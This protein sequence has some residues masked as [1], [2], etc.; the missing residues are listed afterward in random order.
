MP[1]FHVRVPVTNVEGT[2]TFAVEADSK[3]EAIAKAEHGDGDD[4]VEEN[5]EVMGL[6]WDA[7]DVEKVEE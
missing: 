1:K 2:Q 4:F 7:A 6:N 5:L 3:D